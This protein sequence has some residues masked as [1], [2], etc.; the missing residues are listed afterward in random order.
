MRLLK[1]MT[2]DALPHYGVL[3]CHARRARFGMA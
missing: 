1:T 3:H 2:V